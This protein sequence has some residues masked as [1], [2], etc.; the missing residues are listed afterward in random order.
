MDQGRPARRHRARA[1]AQ[2][3]DAEKQR[4]DDGGDGDLADLDSDIEERE[5][6]EHRILRQP[7]VAQRAGETE[8]MNEVKK[9]G[10]PPTTL[11]PPVEEVL[12]GDGD[13]AR[14]DQRFDQAARQADQIKRG[15][16]ERDR[17]GQRE[18]GDHLDHGPEAPGPE[19]QGE[20]E[21]DV[22]VASED[23]P[24]AGRE[25]PA[26]DLG[27]G[28]RGLNFQAVPLAGE[29]GQPAPRHLEPGSDDDPDDRLHPVRPLAPGH[30]G[31]GMRRRGKGR[32]SAPRAAPG[33]P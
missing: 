29:R 14:G 9:E 8:A 26:G 4:H 13:H 17:M 15:Q 28:K 22:V 11:D 10:D 1:R 32:E 23:V 20:Q 21:R 31:G 16:R 19:Q 33:R 24:G 12:Q 27:H 3:V 6:D 18:G 30:A 2:A 7:D 5:G 25:I